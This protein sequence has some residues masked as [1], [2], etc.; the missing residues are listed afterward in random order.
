[1]SVDNVDLAQYPI[2]LDPEI[3]DQTLRILLT[4]PHDL[5]L[6]LD[7]QGKFLLA[8]ETFL[9]RSGFQLHEVLGKTL[10]DILPP[11]LAEARMHVIRRV[12]ATGQPER[13]EDSGVVGWFDNIIYP[14]FDAQG[15][16]EKVVV[17]ARDIS[18]R[19][20]FEA[21][22]QQSLATIQS[23]LEAPLDYA[24]LYDLDGVVLLCNETLA[25]R[26]NRTPAELVGQKIFGFMASEIS[27]ARQE[28]FRQAIESM[29]PVR[30]QDIDE[31]GSFDHLI[32]PI[33][34]PDGK[35]RRVAVTSRDITELHEAEK[36]HQ[37]SEAL[38][39][40]VVNHAPVVLFALDK[41]LNLILLEGQATKAL[42]WRVNELLGINVAAAIRQHQP[43]MLAAIEMA[44][45]RSEVTRTFRLTNGPVLETTLIPQVNANGSVEIIYGMGLDI[46]EQ[47]H[48][49]EKLQQSRNQL[50]VILGGISDSVTVRDSN[51]RLIYANDAAAQMKGYAN[52]CDYMERG[53]PSD[54]FEIVDAN[55]HLMRLEDYLQLR[56]AS[57]REGIPLEIR[58]RRSGS[59]HDRWIQMKTAPIRDE[60]GTIQMIVFISRDITEQKRT[61]DELSRSHNELN[62]RVSE[63]TVELANANQVLRNE[64]ER[65]RQAENELRS[66]VT[67]AEALAR[68]AANLNALHNLRE[69][70]QAVC[71]EVLRISPYETASV[72]LYDDDADH[73]YV[74]AAQ[75]PGALH[76]LQTGPAPRTWYENLMANVNRMV[77]VHD[78]QV[79]TN[80]PEFCRWI[81]EQTRTVVVMT[82]IHA[83]ELIGA[84]L[85]SS[86]ETLNFPRKDDLE[87]LSGVANLGATSIAKGLMFHQLEEARQRLQEMSRKMIDVQDGERRTLAMELHDEVGQMLTT[88]GLRLE[89]VERRAQTFPRGLGLELAEEVNAAR[90]QV[91]EVLQQV[92]EMS[93]RL[94]PAMLDDY[95]LTPALL[96]HFERF[97]AAT[98]I[99]VDF[100]HSGLYDRFPSTIEIA[101]FRM[102]QECLTNVAR[103][104]GV[105][106]VSVRLL[107]EEDLL[108]AQVRDQGVGF[109][110]SQRLSD[111]T[112]SGLSG[113]V[114]RITLCGGKLTIESVP[115]QG[116]CLTAEFP[117]ER[118][119]D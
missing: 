74:A 67:R 56:T 18:E 50:E 59:V 32:T 88:L 92:R 53:S 41:D 4:I 119:A 35:I 30:F 36:A 113:M 99:Q 65:R 49:L 93:Q 34:D 100:R 31:G 2:I 76:L 15:L 109:D 25:K 94:R 82:M 108:V 44:Q 70:V 79:Y 118:K 110:P 75:G 45:S 54:E 26:F 3:R 1:M 91:G 24:A 116:A 73:L 62:Q 27:A 112:S 69:I 17:Q 7:R 104:A 23:L 9:R 84:L 106:E 52:A 102:V 107:A 85:V 29:R 77:V 57:I 11:A 114:E 66:A 103:Y 46:T 98:N 64:V 33:K 39:R 60:G 40:T 37:R 86:S 89:Q 97:S 21:E 12:V 19:K 8:N 43:D 14:I 47:T 68:I 95:G 78:A 20:R 61:L 28:Y 111:H 55:G 6:L 16:V 22:L 38:L 101:V 117:L 42:G 5:I 105:Q 72:F 48:A 63:R 115:G 81:D 96:A 87:A 71:H 10:D 90:Q 83:G 51:L 13:F 58:Y 80:H